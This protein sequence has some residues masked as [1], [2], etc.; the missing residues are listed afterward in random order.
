MASPWIDVSV[1]LKTGMASWPGDPP[2]RISHALGMERGD[3]CTV[4]LLEMGAHT[5]THMDAPAHFVRGGL[6]IDQMPPDASLGPARVIPIRDRE[7]IEPDELARH[8]IRRGER[9]LFKTRNSDRCWD[10]DGFVEDFVYISAAGARYLAERRVRLVGVDYLSVGGYRA[11]GVETHRALLEAGIWIIEG[12][13]LK[14]VRP[15]RVELLCLPLKI[16]GGDG[17]PARALVRRS[18]RSGGG[19]R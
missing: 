16:L 17:A 5:G 14:R 2:A 9:I 4:S 1:T 3:R 11:D 10:A 8:S 7:S 18:R 19:R 6:G 13:D 15:G 12:L